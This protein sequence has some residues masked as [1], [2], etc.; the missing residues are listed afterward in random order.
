[1]PYR[2]E[3]GFDRYGMHLL[4]LMQAFS[5]CIDM[6]PEILVRPSEP[7][8]DVKFIH[9]SVGRHDVRPKVS[10]MSAR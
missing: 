1:M 9:N 3:I 2:F 8:N 10:Y 5:D 7:S 6:T 4:C